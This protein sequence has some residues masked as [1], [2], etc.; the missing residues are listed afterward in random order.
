MNNYNGSLSPWFKI[1][2]VTACI[3]LGVG[4]LTYERHRIEVETDSPQVYSVKITWWGLKEKRTEI[5]W[6]KPPGYDFF[7]WCARGRDG[8]WYIY[9][10][11]QDE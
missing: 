9:L 5:Q 8:D 4:S 2:V 10:V 6:R 1:V 3:M 11:D 7:A